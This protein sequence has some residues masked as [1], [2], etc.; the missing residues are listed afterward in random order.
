LSTCELFFVKHSAELVEVV[1][2]YVK[3]LCDTGKSG[4]KGHIKEFEQF[5]DLMI[6]LHDN[7]PDVFH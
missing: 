1:K 6:L 5:I 2:K 7:N 4:Y 3:E